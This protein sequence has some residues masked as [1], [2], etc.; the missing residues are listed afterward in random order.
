MIVELAG[1]IID[2]GLSMVVESGFS[3]CIGSNIL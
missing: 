2:T 3:D 1:I